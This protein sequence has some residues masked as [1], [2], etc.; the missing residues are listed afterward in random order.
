[1]KLYGFTPSPNTCIE[2]PSHRPEAIA[3]AI[4]LQI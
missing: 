3:P 4:S 1:M 2:H